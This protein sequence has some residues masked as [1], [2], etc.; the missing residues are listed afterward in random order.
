MKTTITTSAAC[1]AA[2]LLWVHPASAQIGEAMSWTVGGEAREA[3]VYAPIRES[4]GGRAPL[5]LS[6]HGH[7]DNVENFQFT[8]MHRAWPEAIVVYFQGLRRS[9]SG[10]HG[11]QV[12]PGQEAD[13]DVK[14]VDAAVASL[15]QRFK[16]DDARIY[17]TGFSNGGH[18]TY[19]LWAARPDLFAAY[20]P[21]AAR[22]RPSVRLLR[23]APVFHVGGGR[24]FQ[25]AF[26]DQE[27][28]IAAAKRAN[29]VT[30]QGTS[31][32]PSCTLWDSATRTPVMTW[33]HDGGHE[34]PEETSDRIARFFRSHSRPA[35]PIRTGESR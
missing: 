4:A 17:A 10:M 14:L 6:F 16:V 23:P 3:I 18:F 12:E 13:R 2:T 11:W 30:G 29:G 35:A 28:A 26:A 34:Y 8:M 1:V 9:D 27:E 32:G 33:I 21:V 7:G 25:V 31:C 24:D 5:V 22:L 15:R 19:L 20:A